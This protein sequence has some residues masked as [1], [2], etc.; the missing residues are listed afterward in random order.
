MIGLELEDAEHLIE[1][2]PMLRRH[3]DHAFEDVG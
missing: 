2:L 3:A 1:H